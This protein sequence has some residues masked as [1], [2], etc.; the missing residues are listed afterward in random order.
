METKI[1]YIKRQDG[2]YFF[3]ITSSILKS[4]FKQLSSPNMSDNFRYEGGKYVGQIKEE[5]EAKF[6][7]LVRR[8]NKVSSKRAE[9]SRSKTRAI[10][11]STCDHPDLGSMGYRHGSRVKCPFCGSMCEVW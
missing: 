2:H 4:H 11:G 5:N 8:I 10:K 1:E 3:K 6:L 9:A 7:D